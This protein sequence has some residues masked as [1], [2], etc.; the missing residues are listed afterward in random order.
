MV[1]WRVLLNICNA[2]LSKALLGR[3]ER[4]APY[5]RSPPVLFT[6]L[7]DSLKAISA[8]LDDPQINVWITS[9]HQRQLDRNI[10]AHPS[11]AGLHLLNNLA[12]ALDIGEVAR[13][14]HDLAVPH[15]HLPII[16]HEGEA[17]LSSQGYDLA[18]SLLLMEVIA[19]PCLRDAGV[20]VTIFAGSLAGEESAHF[21]R[22]SV[23]FATNGLRFARISQV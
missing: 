14:P 2:F 1:L 23:A 16:N 21:V 19:S 4:R 5:G 18:S 3:V 8:S 7:R 12:I 11:I 9:C 10:P 17:R 15:L 20:R 6:A 22:A 13:I